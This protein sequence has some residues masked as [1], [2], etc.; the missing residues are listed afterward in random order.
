MLA[1]QKANSLT[2]EISKV[3]YLSLRLASS[4]LQQ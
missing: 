4:D 2:G 1:L 3:V